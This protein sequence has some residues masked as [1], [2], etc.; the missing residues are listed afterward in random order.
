GYLRDPELQ[1]KRITPVIDRAL[2]RGVYVIM[3]WHDHHADKNVKEAVEFLT[4]FRKI[5][6]LTAHCI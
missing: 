2:Q 5:C 3:D 1:W 6:P 4:A